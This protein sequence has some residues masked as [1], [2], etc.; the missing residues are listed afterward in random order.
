MT[1]RVQENRRLK[2]TLTTRQPHMGMLEKSMLR[3]AVRLR[4][5][6]MVANGTFRIVS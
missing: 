1:T 4:H 3:S 5:L 2:N 6:S